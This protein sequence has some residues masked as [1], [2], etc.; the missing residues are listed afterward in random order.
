MGDLEENSISKGLEK[1]RK[2]EMSY[3]HVGSKQQTL[4]ISKNNEQIC[5]ELVSE[6]VSSCSKNANL[7]AVQ[8]TV[9]DLPATQILIV[10]NSY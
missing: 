10:V 9:S 3:G 8:N 7:P 5:R 2:E 1:Q 4:R 6:L